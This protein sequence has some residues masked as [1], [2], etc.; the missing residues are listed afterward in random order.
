MKH[1]AIMMGTL[2]LG[3]ACASLAAVASCTQGECTREGNITDGLDEL[4]LLSISTKVAQ[5]Q[6]R[7]VQFEV[8]EGNCGI[9]L[10]KP[11]KCLG[12]GDDQKCWA[13]ACRPCCLPADAKKRPELKDK[14]WGCGNA[15]IAKAVGNVV[16]AIKFTPSMFE[17]DPP[18]FSTIFAHTCR[19][20]GYVKSLN[21]LMYLSTGTS[22]S[23]A[24]GSQHRNHPGIWLPVAGVGLGG[25]LGLDIRGRFVA[26]QERGGAPGQ[27]HLHI[28][29]KIV[30]KDVAHGSKGLKDSLPI[31]AESKPES[32][33]MCDLADRLVSNDD[34]TASMI[35]TVMAKKN[36]RYFPE[37]RK[38]P[39]EELIKLN[40]ALVEVKARPSKKAKVTGYGWSSF[41]DDEADK[42]GKGNVLILG[43][44]E[45]LCKYFKQAGWN[46][47]LPC[48]E[49]PTCL[50][51]I[52]QNADE[53]IEKYDLGSAGVRELAAGGTTTTTEKP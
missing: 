22:N 53:F 44:D 30:K 33:S 25:F 28:C 15:G 10:P 40:D 34:L 18:E 21:A 47:R 26:H 41:V 50:K 2:L 42:L 27:H 17:S 31:C 29:A 13:P 51:K 8:R 16:E 24:D 3:L 4:S 46:Q 6:S 1:A 14:Y 5:R 39:Y 36:P 37:S 45:A 52:E 11:E 7:K 23:G 19:T 38:G 43:N 32:A 35:L 9:G 49:E 48:T 12:E 20:F